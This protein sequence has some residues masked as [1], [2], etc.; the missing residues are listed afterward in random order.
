MPIYKMVMEKARWEGIS[1]V[2][3]MSVLTLEGK[4]SCLRANP[5][6]FVGYLPSNQ[7]K[8]SR[9][10]EANL[11]ID[12]LAALLEMGAL[13]LLSLLKEITHDAIMHLQRGVGKRRCQFHQGG[14]Q[15]RIPSLFLKA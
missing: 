3:F 1:P 14:N 11:F 9:R 10:V 12:G 4:C 8:A 15:G 7:G 5:A 2:A 13:L 6:H